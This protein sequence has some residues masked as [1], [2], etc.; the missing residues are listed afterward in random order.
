MSPGKQVLYSVAEELC[1]MAGG[2]V[3]ASFD[4]LVDTLSENASDYPKF[5]DRKS[6]VAENT[7]Y[8]NLFNQFI[9][10]SDF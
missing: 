1:H 6:K 7:T 2:K 9:D 10:E 3:D 4:K 8:E 5:A